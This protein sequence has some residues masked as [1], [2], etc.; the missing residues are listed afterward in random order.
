[1]IPS[2]RPTTAR[3]L[4]IAFAAVAAT[5]TLS[6]AVTQLANLR[7]RSIAGEIT[8][9]TSPTIAL[10]SAIR[11]TIRE[12]EEAAGDYVHDCHARA[13]A[14]V[15]GELETLRKKLQ[16]DWERYQQLPT[17]PGE[18]DGWPMV[19][20]NLQ[21]LDADLA[22][23]FDQL[24]RSDPDMAEAVFRA[25]VE[26]SFDALDAAVA[27]VVRF[28]YAYG[29]ALTSKIDGLARRSLV[30]AVV[31]VVASIAL[32]AFTAALAIAVVRRQERLLRLHAEDLDRFAG[33]V[34]HEVSGPLWAASAAL[35]VLSHTT[36]NGRSDA[37]K[38]AARSIELAKQ[39]TKGL[40][41]FARSGATSDLDTWEDLST[42]MEAIAENLRPLAEQNGVDLRFQPPIEG[43]VACRSGIL[44]SVVSNLAGNAIKHMGHRELRRVVVRTRDGNAPDRI[45]VEV[46]DTGP[47]IPAALGEKLFEPFVR[48]RDAKSPGFGLGLATVKRLVTAHGGAVGLTPRDGGG[49]VFW[50]EMPRATPR[51]EPSSWMRPRPSVRPK[52]D[53]D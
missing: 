28:D 48:G 10:L 40:L 37:L 34:A 42:V 35:D 19:E 24:A 18:R 44:E 36:E 8:E 26:P 23:T 14:A 33:R 46:E 5:F 29:I 41:D 11:S 50:I 6:I 52:V 30:F 47:G 16:M 21:R 27:D 45:R 22:A 2:S 31:L 9:N 4:G 7:I 32:T 15:P 1:M 3:A 39:L 49:T 13:C 17:S 53:A 38:L 25:K 43:R 20:R 12:L 51:R